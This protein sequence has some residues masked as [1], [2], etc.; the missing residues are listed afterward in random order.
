MSYFCI[1]MIMMVIPWPRR[2]GSEKRGEGET[3]EVG[4]L[5]RRP[6]EKTSSNRHVCRVQAAARIST[7][8]LFVIF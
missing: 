6:G 8:H 2:D 4:A 1:I 3:E 5:I 7:N